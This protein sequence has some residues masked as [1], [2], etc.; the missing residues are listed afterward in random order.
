VESIVI[1]LTAVT[2]LISTQALSVQ[3]KSVTGTRNLLLLND[4]AAF[5]KLYLTADSVTYIF[6][7]QW[8]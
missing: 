2:L 5:R 7:D 3:K 4:K 6:T 1:L 8:R